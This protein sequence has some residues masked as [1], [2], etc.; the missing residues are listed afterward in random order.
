MAPIPWLLTFSCFGNW[1]PGDPRGYIERIPG[2]GTRRSSPNP[3]LQ[4]WVAQGME[5]PPFLLHARARA[6]VRAAIRDHCAHAGWALGALHVGRNHLH[7]VVSGDAPPD[8]MMGQMKS[9][10]TRYLRE[11][12]IVDDGRTVWARHG[13]TVP[14]RTG[15]AVVAACRYVIE[16][17][18]AQRE[19]W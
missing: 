13:S 10:A 18:G 9:W 11:A 7:V 15:D 12:A 2:G 1:L 14:L 16:G 3:R 8:R 6:V 17:Q 4:K 5:Q 19:P